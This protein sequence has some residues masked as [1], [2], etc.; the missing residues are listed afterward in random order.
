[1]RGGWGRDRRNLLA[2][3][4]V[5]RIIQQNQEGIRSMEE[6]T[7]LLV[8][9]GAAAAANCIPCFDYYYRKAQDCGLA[10]EDIQAAVECAYKIKNN[11]NMLMKNSIRTLMGQEGD[12]CPLPDDKC[13]PKCGS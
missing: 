10:P 3:F 1:M 13:S 2:I 12:A 4:D 9:L 5:S 11:I 8:C 7:Q 6:K